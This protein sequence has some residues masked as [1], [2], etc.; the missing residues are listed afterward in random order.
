MDLC[1]YIVKS[2]I[3]SICA[4]VSVDEVVRYETCF[5]V[6]QKQLPGNVVYYA[7]K[8]ISQVDDDVSHSVGLPCLAN[9]DLLEA[10]Y[11]VESRDMRGLLQTLSLRDVIRCEHGFWHFVTKYDRGIVNMPIT[12]RV[13]IV[14]NDLLSSLK[15]Y[16]MRDGEWRRNYLGSANSDM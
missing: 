5:L 14:D 15:V 4:E 7:D 16:E 12:M 13:P 6:I 3:G 2:F 10:S 11:K 1:K 8:L 9:S